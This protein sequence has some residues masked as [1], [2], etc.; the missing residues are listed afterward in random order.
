MRSSVE[1]I[2]RSSQV[3][4]AERFPWP[5]VVYG[6][7]GG[8]LAFCCCHLFALESARVA[9][10]GF[11]AVRSRPPVELR[12]YHLPGHLQQEEQ[13]RRAKDGHERGRR[14]GA[15]R[16]LSLKGAGPQEVVRAPMK[17]VRDPEPE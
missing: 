3:K 17:I 12:W 4:N 10:Y 15:G 13:S 2:R 6:I 11:T 8:C 16:S 7:I 14:R 5:S 9:Q 1:P